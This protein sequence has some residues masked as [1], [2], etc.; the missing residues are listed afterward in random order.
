M[1]IDAVTDEPPCILI[2][3]DD[4]QFGLIL[5]DIAHE[6]VSGVEVHRVV[7]MREALTLMRTR[8]MRELVPYQLIL[9]DF[10]LADGIWR[11]EDLPLIYDIDPHAR[12][13][14]ISGSAEG[15]DEA[16]AY[17]VRLYLLKSPTLKRHTI[18][19]AIRSIMAGGGDV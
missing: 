4:K 18:L 19:Q 5:E 17:N 10:T 13:L 7:T 9:L 15:R 14:V 3:E 1:R 16:K 11:V 6:A 8:Q 2:I 12:I